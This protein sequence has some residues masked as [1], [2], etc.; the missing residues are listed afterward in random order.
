MERINE[1]KG[2]IYLVPRTDEDLSPFCTYFQLIFNLPHPLV[3]LVSPFPPSFYMPSLLNS[4]STSIL[5]PHAIVVSAYHPF[6]GPSCTSWRS[7]S[8][9]LKWDTRV[10]MATCVDTETICKSR[11]FN[12]P[13]LD[14]DPPSLPPTTLAA[15]WL[16]K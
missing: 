6:P 9:S 13:R 10:E 2:Y 12:T 4:Y 1:K 8:C 16:M 14:M 7:R 5:H 3:V 15:S 11:S